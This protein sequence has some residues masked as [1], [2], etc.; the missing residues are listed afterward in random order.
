MKAIS[1]RKF[2]YIFASLSFSYPLSAVA[3]SSTGNKLEKNDRLP[4]T[5]AVLKAAFEA[6][7]LASE[8]YVAY[9]RKAA[10]EKY[11]NIAYLFKAF[12]VSEKIHAENYQRIL[13]TLSAAP[14]APEF[15]ILILDTKANLINASEGELKKI[16]Q[17][18]PDFLAKLKNES[19]AP[20]VVNCMYS[21]KSHQ[22][23]ERK[24][25]EIRK[26]SEMFFGSVA[27]TIEGAKFDFYVCEI[28]GSTIDEAPKTPC[29]ICNHPTLH[30]HQVTR[31][32]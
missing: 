15:K 8:N 29:D 9:S 22:Q 5:I 30:Y 27:K 10:E 28:C 13:A 19:Y 31:P 26:Y 2:L 7:M 32:A 21:W 4:I 18:Y 14:E 6:E 23:H 16:K 24:I 20:A 17:T 3:A 1:R 11:L 12:S 25:G